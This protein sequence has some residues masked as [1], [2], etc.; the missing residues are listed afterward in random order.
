[1]WNGS[2]SVIR[3]PLLA[4]CC[5][6]AQSCPTLV[7]RGLW[8]VD[9]GPPGSSVPG[10]FQVL[11]LEWA[12]I[13]SSRGP[14]RPKDRICASSKSPALQTN[15]LLCAA[16]TDSFAQGPWSSEV[17]LFFFLFFFCYFTASWSSRWSQYPEMISRQK[18]R[19]C[20]SMGK[21]VQYPLDLSCPPATRDYW[22]LET[23]LVGTEMSWMGEIHN[24]FWTPNKSS[25]ISH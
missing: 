18:D 21:G 10:I 16:W 17:P 20:I 13:S 1:M 11:I 24:G 22:V 4:L 9:C 3:L 15:S 8:T 23:W 7:T 12:A 2:T 5:L 19:V 6:V 25:K 14:S